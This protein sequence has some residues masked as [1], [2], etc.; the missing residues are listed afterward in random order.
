[1]TP[2]RPSPS[3]RRRGC[4]GTFASP[5]AL[6]PRLDTRHEN[7]QPTNCRS[8]CSKACPQVRTGRSSSLPRFSKCR[9]NRPTS[10]PLAAWLR[11]VRPS[12]LAQTRLIESAR[13]QIQTIKNLFIAAGLTGRMRSTLY[14]DSTIL[15]QPRQGVVANTLKL[16]CNW[17]LR[18]REVF[19]SWLHRIG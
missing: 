4:L 10:E 13:E 5:W 16:L 8:S 9:D 18:A 7:L 19:R 11:L 15:S 1:H 6:S 12:A 14:L 2:C 3:R 17:A